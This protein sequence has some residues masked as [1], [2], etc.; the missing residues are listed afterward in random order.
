MTRAHVITAM[1]TA[2]ARNGDGLIELARAAD[3]HDATTRLERLRDAQAQFRH[4]LEMI[5]VAVAV[6]TK[7]QER[8]A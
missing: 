4:I 8:A 7:Q 3:E 2:S 1:H 6:E 5:D